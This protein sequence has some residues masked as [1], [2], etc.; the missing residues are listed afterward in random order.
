MD[1]SGGYASRVF[2]VPATTRQIVG[3]RHE[4]H[5][6]LFAEAPELYAVCV[7]CTDEGGL[8]VW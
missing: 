2:D 1:C 4:R 8:S 5:A 3:K 7:A 6:K